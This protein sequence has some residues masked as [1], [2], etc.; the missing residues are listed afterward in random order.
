MLVVLV[1]AVLAV[2]SEQTKVATYRTPQKS[3]DQHVRADWK[4][5]VVQKHNETKDSKNKQKQNKLTFKGK[6]LNVSIERYTAEQGTW[7]AAEADKQDRERER[8]RKW[9]PLCHQWQ[10]SERMPWNC[11]AQTA[12]AARTYF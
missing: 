2:I 7:R 5:S 10:S 3:S 12:A 4:L 8:E 6:E 11:L 1:A 9:G